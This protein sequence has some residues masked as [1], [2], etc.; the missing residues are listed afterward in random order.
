MNDRFWDFVT[1]AAGVLLGVFL[2]V[3]L[4]P[5]K[6]QLTP[7][8]VTPE[9]AT[10]EKYVDPWAWQMDMTGLDPTGIHRE[11]YWLSPAVDFDGKE[12]STNFGAMWSLNIDVVL[13][14]LQPEKHVKLWADS[15]WRIN[16]GLRASG[17]AVSLLPGQD[18]ELVAYGPAGLFGLEDKLFSVACQGE[19]F[20]GFRSNVEFTKLAIRANPP[21]QVS[22]FWLGEIPLTG[23]TRVCIVNARVLTGWALISNGGELILGG[24]QPDGCMYETLPHPDAPV[25]GL[26]N[27]YI[28]P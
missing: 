10:A 15:E 8:Q 24:L 6:A 21:L 18:V 9:R 20:C 19:T 13:G 11:P 7:L 17:A 4:M 16:P 26:L 12:F 1:I 27:F 23:S 14:Y 2:L 25:W 3:W 5:A 22:A 28:T